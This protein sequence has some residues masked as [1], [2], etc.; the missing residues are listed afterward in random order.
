ML[1]K[2][3]GAVVS[4]QDAIAKGLISVQLTGAGGGDTSKVFLQIKNL[5][6][7]PVKIE[8]PRGTTFTPQEGGK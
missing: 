5:S 7:A 8:I 1:F 2:K 6:D 4:I 3:K